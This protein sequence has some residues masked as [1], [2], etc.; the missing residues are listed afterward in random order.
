[1]SINEENKNELEELKDRGLDTGSLLAKFAE[2]KHKHSDIFGKLEEGKKDKSKRTRPRRKKS[3]KSKKIDKNLNLVYEIR[4]HEHSENS[5]EKF[6]IDSSKNISEDKEDLEKL[7]DRGLDTGSL[8]AKLSELKHNHSDIFDKL[9]TENISIDSS[10]NVSEE[11]EDLEELRDRGLDTGSLL[12]KFSELKHKQDSIFNKLEKEK[13]EAKK[14]LQ[15]KGQSFK[16]ELHEPEQIEKLHEPEQIE[17]LHEPEQIEELH[18]PEQIEELQEP[19]QIEELQESEQIEEL[20]EPEQIE[21]SQEPEQIEKLQEPEQIEEKQKPEQIE[22]LQEPEQIEELQEPE[23]IEKLQ[24]PEQIEESQEPKQIEKLQEP[25]QIEKSQEPEQIEKLQEP[26]QIEESKEPE[27]V[28]KLHK[29]E[30]IEKEQFKESKNKKEKKSKKKKDK[31][32]A[33]D[34]KEKK[35]EKLEEVKELEKKKTEKK[36]EKIKS[37]FKPQIIDLSY[38]PEEEKLNYS[39]GYVH[40]SF[41][42]LILNPSYFFNSRTIKLG[43]AIAYFFYAVCIFS[44]VFCGGNAFSSLLNLTYSPSTTSIL[45]HLASDMVFCAC[46]YV[47]IILVP[48][49]IYIFAIKIFK[50]VGNISDE[51]GIVFYSFGTGLIAFSI[52]ITLLLLSFL[53]FKFCSVFAYGSYVFWYKVAGIAVILIIFNILYK[54]LMEYQELKV[55]HALISLLLPCFVFWIFFSFLPKITN[56]IQHF[57]N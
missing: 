30:Q 55:L 9:E 2:L 39:L 10:K 8:L 24:E 7:R 5:V 23:Q 20:Q 41:W 26:E 13:Q 1:M 52:L 4:E 31:V 6:S 17:E 12:A 43:E 34:S 14:Q 37:E 46:V 3:Y 56:Y 16:E 48:L 44:F 29:I 54:A 32:K 22:K 28:A 19:E 53:W 25:E 45:K 57:I 47:L 50:G 40:R 11:K 36:K 21:E 33:E 15:I 38:Q 35:V 27:Q 49:F 18:E 51:Y 42:E